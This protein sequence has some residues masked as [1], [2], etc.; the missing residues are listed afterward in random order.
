MEAA[1]NQLFEEYRGMNIPVSSLC[2][3]L[4]YHT[5]MAGIRIIYYTR[6]MYRLVGES[7][8]PLVLDYDV[9]DYLT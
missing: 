8:T 2:I 7:N 4:K 9:P 5:F 1:T 6:H 3:V